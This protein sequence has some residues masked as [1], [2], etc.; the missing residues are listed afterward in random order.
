MIYRS[1]HYGL[2]YKKANDEHGFTCV[3]RNADKS[4]QWMHIG[5]DDLSLVSKRV[6]TFE[7]VLNTL[8]K[9]RDY[10]MISTYEVLRELGIKR[11]TFG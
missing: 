8:I 2:F 5:L 7:K 4:M 11:I 6:T 9:G 1:K 10:Y 3:I